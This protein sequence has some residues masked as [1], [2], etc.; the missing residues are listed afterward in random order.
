MGNTCTR[1]QKLG[2][3]VNVVHK[4]KA[5][6]MQP[7]YKNETPDRDNFFKIMRYLWWLSLCKKRESL[8]SSGLQLSWTLQLHNSGSFLPVASPHNDFI[9]L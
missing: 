5:N 1:L 6:G 8:I 3:N 4:Q 9:S 7:A 2:N